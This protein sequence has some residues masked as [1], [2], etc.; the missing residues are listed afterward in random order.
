MDNPT[1][2]REGTERLVSV[3]AGYRAGDLFDLDGWTWVIVDLLDD[4]C[5]R[6][7]AVRPD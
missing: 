5:A 2:I 7:R 4:G 6:A 1:P 3:P